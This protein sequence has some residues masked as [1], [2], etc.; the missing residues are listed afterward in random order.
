MRYR[1]AW[2]G[3]QLYGHCS[4]RLAVRLIAYNK[5]KAERRRKAVNTTMTVRRMRCARLAPVEA[6]AI[7]E[8]LESQV[9]ANRRLACLIRRNASKPP[10]I[11]MTMTIIRVAVSATN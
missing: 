5:S 1:V 9:F 11:N 2:Q 4:E 8:E 6:A 3:P 10:T 7:I